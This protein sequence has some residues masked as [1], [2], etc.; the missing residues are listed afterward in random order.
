MPISIRKHVRSETLLFVLSGA[1]LVA[2]FGG[3]LAAPAPDASSVPSG[4][5]DEV[6]VIA[7]T[8]LRGAAI[9]VDKISSNVGTPAE[10]G[11]CTSTSTITYESSVPGKFASLPGSLWILERNANLHE[12]LI[13]AYLPGDDNPLQSAAGSEL[14]PDGGLVIGDRFGAHAQPLANLGQIVAVCQNY[15]LATR[16][17][18]TAVPPGR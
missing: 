17:T 14:L 2:V 10:S 7:T 3:G 5:L 16:R 12:V 4:R 15:G 1:A 11:G 8:P 18:T 6:P 13:Q 9:D